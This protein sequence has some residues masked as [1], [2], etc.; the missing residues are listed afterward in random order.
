MAEATQ[1]QKIDFNKNNSN[2]IKSLAMKKNTTV[3]VTS[4]F[5]NGKMLMFAK[6]TLVSFIYDVID[7][8][9]FPNEYVRSIFYKDDI[10]MCCLY[11]ILAGTDTAALL[12]VFVCKLHCSIRTHSHKKNKF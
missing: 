5:M 6:V 2:S 4:R 12:F 7:V 3:K 1:N 11:L 10:I 8:F 9:A